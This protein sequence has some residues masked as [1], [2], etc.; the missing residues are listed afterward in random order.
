VAGAVPI[1]ACRNIL[2]KPAALYLILALF[3]GQGS[4]KLSLQNIEYSC[5]Y[6]Q[7][8]EAFHNPLPTLQTNVESLN[9]VLPH[10]DKY[11]VT[12]FQT[13]RNSWEF[14]F[15][16]FSV[17][18][19]ETGLVMLV[20]ESYWRDRK[21]YLCPFAGLRQRDE[22]STYL[23]DT[24]IKPSSVSSLLCSRRHWLWPEPLLAAWILTA[25]WSWFL[26]VAICCPSWGAPAQ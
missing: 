9:S 15:S 19:R 4:A 13:M 14:L 5:A 1:S 26:C 7:F 18:C 25:W 6:V 12:H 20:T 10:I 11:I 16:A 3:C 17:F 24:E 21:L 8:S 22:A 2:G 23:L